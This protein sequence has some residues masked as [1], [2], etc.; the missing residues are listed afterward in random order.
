MTG[1]ALALCLRGIDGVV[2][3]TVITGARVELAARALD[4][5]LGHPG[6]AAWWTWMILRPRGCR[7]G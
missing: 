5:A 6:A 3:T 2:E 7:R 4:R 1:I